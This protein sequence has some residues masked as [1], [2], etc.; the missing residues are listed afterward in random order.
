MSTQTLF[1]I[2][3]GLFAGILIGSV[4][5]KLRDSAGIKKA[6]NDAVK[7]SRAVLGGQFGEQLAPFLPDFPCN[8]GDARFI[9]KPVD[10]IAFPGT[11]EGRSV[12]EILLIEVKSGTSALSAREKE[13]REAVKK[14]RV[15]YVEYRIPGSVL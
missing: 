6:R 9:G 11:A 3:A 13:I 10:Y 5:Q 8:P 2:A 4:V 12:E 1:Y 15:R 7:R 14:G